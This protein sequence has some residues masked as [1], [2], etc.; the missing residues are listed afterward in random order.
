M[1]LPRGKLL[2]HVVS[3]VDISIDLERVKVIYVL[4][5][6]NSKKSIQSFLGK[7]NFVRRFIPNFSYIVKPIHNLLKT[8][9]TFI[10]D[11]KANHYFLKIKYALSSATIL[12]TP[13]FS[14]DFIVYMNA[15][16][17]A[18]SSIL[19]QNNSQ[20]IEQPITFMSQSL[21]N[22][23]VQY[24]LIEKHAYSLVKA[25]EKFRHYILGK[26]IIVKVPLPAVK[27]L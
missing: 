25:I 20:D 16:E 2:G 10:W 27:L 1:A 24:S 13:D 18:I 9:Q 7:I 21:S 14:K 4:P 15:T 23:H 3:E 5:T 11:E 12:A 22:F 26:H 19:I 8:N 17:E 6:P